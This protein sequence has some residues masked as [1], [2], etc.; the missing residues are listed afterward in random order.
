MFVITKMKHII[1]ICRHV[2]A[3]TTLKKNLNFF[4]SPWAS[5]QAAE[6]N[7]MESVFLL[8]RNTC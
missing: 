4:F 3:K 1:F 5:V 7:L 2:K 6:S 8:V